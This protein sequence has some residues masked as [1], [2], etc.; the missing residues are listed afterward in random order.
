MPKQKSTAPAVPSGK[1]K[2][3]NLLKGKKKKKSKQMMPAFPPNLALNVNPWEAPATGA[4]LPDHNVEATIAWTEPYVFNATPNA[5]GN[6][7]F[8]V[9]GSLV[10]GVYLYTLSAAADPATTAV[11]NS[12]PP[13]FA[14]LATT[15]T[16]YR[17]LAVCAEMEYI[18]ESQLCK[19][20]LG[21]A[22]APTLPAAAG[23]VFSS[24]MDEN[25]YRETTAEEKVAG[26]ISFTEGD[27]VAVS[28]GNDTPSI[29][30][31]GSGLPVANN[32][33]R[34]RLRFH[35]EFKVAPTSLY[36]RDVQHTI[37]HPG[38]LAVTASLLGPRASLGAG[39]DPVGEI[40]KHGEKLALL[41]GA[42]NGLWQS[43]KP[44]ATILAEFMA[45]V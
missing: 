4:G 10:N 7:M 37:S 9:R 19:G 30:L 40:V 42:A 14:T 18:G 26:K 24:Y 22:R 36:S 1:A 17:P 13:N 43:A 20:I 29:V 25:V 38:S 5:Q 21:I 44:I 35:F 8:M 27:F 33:V 39:K 2:P 3:V 11:T 32:S 15:F 16:H 6:L 34:I 45:L 12:D 23:A 41:A 31:F 28:S